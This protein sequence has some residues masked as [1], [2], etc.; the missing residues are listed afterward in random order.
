LGGDNWKYLGFA[1]F[2]VLVMK[3][4]R[5][6]NDPSKWGFYDYG[7]AGAGEGLLTFTEVTTNGL[8]KRESRMVEWDNDGKDAP[9]CDAL[10]GDTMSGGE[11]T[12]RITE[13][14][15]TQFWRDWEKQRAA[16][17]AMSAS[18]ARLW[19]AL[20]AGLCLVGVLFWSRRR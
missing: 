15:A 10:F 18:S 6:K 1:W 2:N 8:F 14:S 20:V 13:I 16:P 7:H 3:P 12:K 11:S 9:E 4:A 5:W 19:L 17:S